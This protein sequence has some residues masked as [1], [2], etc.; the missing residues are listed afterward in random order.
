V[1]ALV[2]VCLVSCVVGVVL[3]LRP[4]YFPSGSMENTLRA[5]DH[6]WVERGQDVRRGDIVV[7]TIPSGTRSGTSFQPGTYVKRIIGLPGDHVACCDE[8]GDITV[9]GKALHEQAY[10][11][12][13]NK[14]SVF[15]FSVTLGPGQMWVMGDHRLIS[16]DSRAAGPVPTADIVGHVIQIGQGFSTVNVRTPET[17]VADGLAPPDTREPMPFLMVGAAIILAVVQFALGVLGVT[18]WAIRRSRV[19]RQMMGYGQVT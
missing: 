12:P 18:R 17:F 4:Y 6:M 2:A 13:G 3:T 15:R 8:A 11:Y 7:Y 14:P 19:H 10:L 1:F 5:G 9:N 16:L